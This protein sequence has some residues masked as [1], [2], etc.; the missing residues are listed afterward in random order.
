MEWQAPEYDHFEKTANWF[1]LTGAVA[2]ALIL[3]AVLFKDFLF[4]VVLLLGAFTIMMYAARPPVLIDFALTKKGLRI[5]DRLYPY[6]HL[7]SFWVS[8]E[9]HKRKIIVESDRLVLPHLIVP[10]PPNID[11]EEAREYLLQYLPEMRHEESLIDLLAD[12]LGF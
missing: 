11:D 7:K 6:D 5:K 3:L 8:D 10:L 2:G 9:Y 12:Y 4:A 1:W